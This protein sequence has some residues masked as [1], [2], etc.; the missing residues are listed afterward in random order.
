MVAG[1]I[2][3]VS[4]PIRV[5]TGTFILSIASSTPSTGIAVVGNRFVVTLL[6]G[7]YQQISVM[8]ASSGKAI[9]VRFQLFNATLGIEAAGQDL[10]IPSS[11]NPGLPYSF[12]LPFTVLN[13]GHEFE[14]RLVV[15]DSNTPNIVTSSIL[16]TFQAQLQDASGGGGIIIV[17]T[18][19]DNEYWVDKNGSDLNPGTIIQ[20][21]LTVGR[22]VTVIGNA[23]SAAQFNDPLLRSYIVHI[24]TGTY[25]ENVTMPVRPNVTFK[26]ATNAVI[27]GNLTTTWQAAY[28]TT[29]E[30]T[31][32]QIFM[33]DDQ[34]GGVPTF[35]CLTGIQGNM[36]I[37][38]DGN[39]VFYQVQ[40]HLVGLIGNM[41]W[42]R[43]AGG[44][45]ASAGQVLLSSATID[46]IVSASTQLDTCSIWAH[47][48]FHSTGDDGIGGISGKV[49]WVYLNNVII[50]RNVSGTGNVNGIMN[51]VRWSTGKTVDL[52]SYVGI[53]QFDS[54]TFWNLQLNYPANG[55]PLSKTRFT[56]FNVP[57]KRN[58]VASANYVMVADDYYSDIDFTTG[59]ADRTCTLPALTTVWNRGRIVRVTKVDAT[60]T[61]VT[62]TCAGAD[63]FQN[64]V[65]TLELRSRG[66]TV[67]LI[68]TAAGWK[69]IG[70]TQGGSL[71][72]NIQFTLGD[73][74]GVVPLGI[75]GD[76]LVPYACTIQKV[77]LLADQAG[78]LTVD[79][80]KDTYANFPPTVADTIVAAAKP[81]LVGVN[82]STDSTLTG[83]TKAIAAGDILR[84]NVD[85]SLLVTRVLL[86]LTVVRV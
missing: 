29:Y 53:I 83:W 39:F 79:I 55:L 54:A 66:S 12:Q 41:V 78:N 19:L 50:T 82:K 63:T 16:P 9:P 60:A 40:M 70:M 34:R 51:N 52:S 43:R 35:G 31:P 20:P 84:F 30:R 80:W 42:Q 47:N 2:Q 7:Y 85:A 37:N 71:I 67:T 64:G 62:V 44:A 36:T 59:A 1:I 21:F 24:G 38:V 14:Y 86:S 28:I 6:G 11:M 22:A 27:Q 45:G 77:D 58:A 32:K 61:K 68:G 75:L 15:L 5:G 76:Y 3:G 69:F 13:L 33:G 74:S 25:V 26:F 81:T 72:E 48:Q 56:D 49:S 10:I 73:G 23:T 8:F 18:E 17:P 4:S 65:T 57:F 46:G